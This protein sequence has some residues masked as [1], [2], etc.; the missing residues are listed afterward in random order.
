M[1]ER[2]VEIRNRMIASSAPPRGRE[3]SVA[4]ITSG[5]GLGGMIGAGWAVLD[6]MYHRVTMPNAGASLIV[7]GFALGG[8][9]V[10]APTALLS[11]L[12]GIRLAGTRG[13][14][15]ALG[16]LAGLVTQAVLVLM[17]SG[18]DLLMTIPIPWVFAW[19][20]FRIC[21]RTS[22]GL[23]PGRLLIRGCVVAGCA[24]ALGPLLLHARAPMGSSMTMVVTG[25]ALTLALAAQ[26]VALKHPL[27]VM[28][29]LVAACALLQLW[30]TRIPR[31]I[32]A[33]P[34]SVQAA[35]DARPGADR[36][37]V[38][39]I[40]LDTTRADALG[41]YGNTEGLS[42]RLD[43]LAAE[44]TLY[45]QAI[46]SAPWTVPSHASLFTGYYT[47]THGCDSE[48]HR[49]LDDGFVTLSEH[50]AALGYQTVALSANEYLSASNLLQGFEAQL[51]LDLE[52]GHRRARMHSWMMKAGGPEHYSDM[53]AAES[54]VALDQWFDATR[55]TARPFFLFVNLM[56][57][58]W[59]LYPPYAE[60]ERC[61]PPGVGYREATKISSRY[62]GIRWMA[63]ARHTPRDVSVIRR[64][65]AAEVAYQDRQLGSLLDVLRRRA[66][67]DDTI[68][69][70]TADH[71]E[72]LGDGGRWDHVFALNDALIR[73]PLIIRYPPRFPAGR[74]VE[75]QCQLIDVVPTVLDVLRQSVP[76]A[77]LPGRPLAPDVFVPREFTFAESFPYYGHLERM[78]AVT[79]FDRDTVEFLDVLRAI[80]T[81]QHKYV[82]SSRG[83]H[84]LHDLHDDPDEEIDLREQLPDLTEKL[85]I[86]LKEWYKGQPP[87]V[88][89][90]GASSTP[91]NAD[92]IRSLR[93]LGYIGND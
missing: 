44:A 10:L 89:R 70:I 85:E 12:V 49:W 9:V 15:A 7:L 37:N 92:S 19:W 66:D 72:N 59:P 38:V 52:S 25:A 88:P 6:L 67:F 20:A 30:G 51:K 21:E 31:W 39:L 27:L 82:W 79:G 73:V 22:P 33:T 5:A 83:R 74:R 40:V 46:S 84:R 41:C 63:G 13:P 24:S 57:A 86:A 14:A 55:D 48:P 47:V 45:E 50:L 4:L 65:Y 76:A 77:D 42:P 61:L 90:P 60:R 87:Y 8:A 75:G 29:P 93:S 64:L 69:I 23:A 3:S 17:L 18:R 1:T 36:P 11:G 81:G 34:S 58:H 54:V 62:Y 91:V 2:S 28:A 43:A 68:V 16:L 71:G 53:G 32:H 80:R 56:E 35:P 78:E 26:R